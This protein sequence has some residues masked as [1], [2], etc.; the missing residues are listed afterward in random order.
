MFSP[1]F[2]GLFYFINSIY[3]FFTKYVEYKQIHN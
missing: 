1:E 3:L 2:S